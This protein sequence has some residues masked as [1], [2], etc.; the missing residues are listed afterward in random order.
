MALVEGMI[1]DRWHVLLAAIWHWYLPLCG[2][3]DGKIQ[4]LTDWFPTPVQQQNLPR[5]IQLQLRST[6]E[7]LHACYFLHLKTKVRSCCLPF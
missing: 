4:V 2:L 1:D 3:Q 5:F 7:F 6:V